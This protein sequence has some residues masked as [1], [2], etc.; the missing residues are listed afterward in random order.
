M[1]GDAPKHKILQGVALL[2]AAIVVLTLISADGV[3]A[4]HL[5]IGWMG[6]IGLT[7]TGAFVLLKA[8]SITK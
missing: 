4:K 6:M 5:A 1:I 2:V 8:A 7:V 3:S